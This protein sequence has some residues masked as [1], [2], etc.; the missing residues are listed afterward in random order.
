[1]FCGH[2]L[3][4]VGTHKTLIRAVPRYPVELCTWLKILT[5]FVCPPGFHQGGK[6]RPG[7]TR[8]CRK[9]SK[10]RGV[11]GTWNTADRNG[12]GYAAK[13]P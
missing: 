9:K 8:G 2:R 4:A 13:A 1:M 3:H 12:Q 10:R 5:H 11:K 7:E 6:T